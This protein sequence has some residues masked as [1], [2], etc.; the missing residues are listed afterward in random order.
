MNYNRNEL[1][2]E[3]FVAGIVAEVEEVASGLYEW[4]GEEVRT[5]EVMEE[6]VIGTMRRLGRGLLQR[7]CEMRVP[8]Y[9]AA[10]VGC[11][12]GG[13]ASYVSRRRGQTKT[14]L[15][16]IELSRPYYLCASCRQGQHP[17][18]DE[19]GFCAGGISSGLDGLLAY[20]GSLLPY[21]ETVHLIERVQGISVST[22]RVRASTERLGELVAAEEE[23]LMA[24]AWQTQDPQCPTPVD[25]LTPLYISMDGIKVN[26]RE[27]AWKE[28][29]LGAVYSAEEVAARTP[30]QEPVIRAHSMS[31]FTAM[32]DADRFGRG[33]WIEAQRRGLEHAEQVIV[34]GDGAQWI[35]RLAQEH[36]PQATQILDWYH[37]TEYVWKAAHAIYGE[38][39]PLAKRWAR[40]QLDQL[41]AGRT[42][43]VIRHLRSHEHHK[44]VA[45][46][47]RY[48]RNNRQRMHYPDY[49]AQGLQIGS[50]TIESGC[51]HVIAQ[52]FKQAGMRWSMSHLQTVAK[53]R[54]RLKSNRWQET[55][56]LRPPPART[57]QRKAA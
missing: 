13:Q 50:G 28:Q 36:F 26:T 46:A 15:D 16:W 38:D 24:A 27:E 6:A 41:W 1:S 57:Y 30:E 34:I 33:L 8:R 5:L 29:R 10:S 31:Y 35:W 32:E 22:G 43:K 49:R 2:R 18:D 14:Q 17:V 56:D 47:I 23:R 20:V 19:L 53:L 51:K 4:L 44:A 39:N 3:A 21:E 55:L 25:Q 11:G 48:F 40:Q 52:R 45:D 7:A 12:C 42:H 37:V 9:P 54:C